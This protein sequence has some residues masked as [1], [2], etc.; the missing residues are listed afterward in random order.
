MLGVY[1]GGEGRLW[2][3][4]WYKTVRLALKL[5]EVDVFSSVDMMAEVS[6]IQTNRNNWLFRP[7]Q[8]CLCQRQQ[9]HVNQAETESDLQIGGGCK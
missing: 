3:H 6:Y 2:Q 7:K 1:F 4:I 8:S 5:G 9:I